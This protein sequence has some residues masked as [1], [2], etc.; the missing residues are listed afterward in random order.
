LSSIDASLAAATGI[1]ASSVPIM[2]G[3]VVIDAISGFAKCRKCGFSSKDRKKVE[4]HARHHRIKVSKK[5][6]SSKKIGIDIYKELL[7]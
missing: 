6:R 5:R 2:A 1:I 4:Q 7:G 3:L